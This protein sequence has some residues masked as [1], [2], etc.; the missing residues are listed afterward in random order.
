[1]EPLNLTGN[2][3]LAVA[4][5]MGIALGFALIKADLCWRK[6]VREALQL[7]NGR[8]I[9]S[10]F[11]MFALGVILFFWGSKLGAMVLHVRPIYL[12]S[13]L[14]GGM[15]AG[16]GLVMTS[17]T[18]T[19]AIAS[20]ASGRLHAL[21]VLI[22][23]AL[24]IPAVKYISATLSLTLYSWDLSLSGPGAGGGAFFDRTN[25]ALY[26]V[27]IMIF[28]VLLVHFTIGDSEE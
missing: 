15:L 12:W 2:Y 5:V 27:T 6:P 25:P 21:W 1:M 14:I 7:R 17:L 16:A 26:I 10:V 22:G 8:V 11:T 28:L 23:M 18:P 13:S 24:A 3:R 19:T 9:K 4:V 20:L